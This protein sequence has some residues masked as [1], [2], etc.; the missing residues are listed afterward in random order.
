MRSLDETGIWA[1]GIEG[2][3]VPGYDRDA[4]GRGIVHIGVGGF[5]RAHLAMYVD[6]LLASGG[7]PEWGIC[8]VGVLA[9]DDRMR[10]VLAAQDGLYTLVLK[11]ADGT[12][13]PRVVGSLVDYLYAPTTP[14]PSSSGSP[15]PTPGSSR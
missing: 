5:H 14:R 2:V 12:L 9:A 1:D 7:A 13:T 3:E 11:E 8:G 6:A 10:D 4:V 15:T